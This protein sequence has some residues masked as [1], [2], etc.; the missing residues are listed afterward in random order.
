MSG[1]NIDPK[2]KKKKG[3]KEGKEKKEA[4]KKMDIP[5]TFKIFEP[6]QIARE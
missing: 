2:G 1:I 3:N 6:G 5:N 4:R